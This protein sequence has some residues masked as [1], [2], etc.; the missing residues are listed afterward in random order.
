MTYIR[1]VC[2]FLCFLSISGYIKAGNNL[3]NPK[4]SIAEKKIE[5][6][7]NELLVNQQMPGYSIAVTSEGSLFYINS[8][9][10]S[11][12]KLKEKVTNQ[13]L[14]QIGS[15]TKSFTAIALL[16]LLSGLSTSS[17]SVAM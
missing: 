2:V 3:V 4:T 16:V 8:F 17:S 14:F 15:I 7:I 10:F 5:K 12:L 9:G 11:D 13:T 6:Y 1:N